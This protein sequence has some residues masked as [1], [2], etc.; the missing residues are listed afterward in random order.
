MPLSVGVQDTDVIVSNNKDL[1][2]CQQRPR[3]PRTRMSFSARAAVSDPPACRGL[4][5]AP[6]PSSQS[7]SQRAEVEVTAMQNGKE[8]LGD[9]LS[10]SALVSSRLLQQVGADLVGA[11]MTGWLYKK[12]GINTG[13]QRRY[14][15]L[16][17][18]VLT[19]YTS[20][21]NAEVK[22]AVRKHYTQYLRCHGLEIEPDTGEDGNGRFWFAIKALRGSTKRRIEL[23]CEC[24][25]LRLKWVQALQMNQSHWTSSGPT[26]LKRIF[27]IGPHDISGPASRLIHPQSPFALVWLWVTCVCL[28]YTAIVTPAVLSFHWLDAPCDTVPTLYFDCFLDVFFLCDILV[29]FC[30]GVSHRGKYFDDWKWVAWNYATSSFPFDLCTSI[31]V[32]FVELAIQAA[33]SAATPGDELSENANS[34]QLRFVRILKPLRWLKLS[35]IIKLNGFGNI[36]AS[37]CDMLD[38]QPRY[39]RLFLLAVHIIGNDSALLQKKSSC[40]VSHSR[41]KSQSVVLH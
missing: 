10:E 35:R 4:K 34:I 30:L 22:R 26:I 39:Q 13:V 28:A 24:K 2:S 32:S 1:R 20:P 29:S 17:E 33:C 19:W 25:S 8:E 31:P 16:D 18:G 40:T 27:G 12:G 38:V 11:Q 6:P 7:P 21:Q 9:E 5:P 41:V 37:V 36:L 23:A 15:V 14:F 3:E